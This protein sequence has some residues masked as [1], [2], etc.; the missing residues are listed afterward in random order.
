MK[1]AP[2]PVP[3]PLVAAIVLNWNGF[4]DTCAAVDSLLTQT[5]RELLVHVVDNASSGDDADRLADRYGDRIRLR[6]HMANLGFPDGHNGL[7]AE[8]LASPMGPAYVV[9]LNNDA[10]AAP[11]W[12][13]RLVDAAEGDATV[14]ACTS[15]MLFRDRPEVVE[16]AG[17]VMLHSGEAIPRGRGRPASVFATA[18][19]VLGAC[20]G[21]ALFRAAALRQVGLFRSEFFLNFEDVDLSLRLVAAGWRIRYVPEAKVRHGLNQSI[22]KVRD[23]AFAIRSI[24]NMDFAY[25]INMPWPVLLAAT[26]WLLLAW[27]AAPFV[28]VLGGQ[29]AYARLLVRGHARTLRERRDL[30]AARAALRPLR[31]A[32]SWRLFWAH[33][34]TLR[35]YGRFLRDVV[36]L[37][38][39]AAMH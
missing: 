28:C 30:L 10:V 13:E 38:R 29:F 25:L 8:L 18:V 36:V 1:P 16:N 4:A 21:A 35:A 14:G 32:S 15:L 31:R 37:R 12:V 11:D 7:L 2:V 27:V 22:A 33:G 23:E 39:R 17:I 24:R 5:W 6:R 3:R 26:P 19:D 9:L 34:S 20:A